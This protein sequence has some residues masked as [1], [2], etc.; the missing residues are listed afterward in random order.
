MNG[1]DSS[2]SES[3][4]REAPGHRERQTVE[5]E[6]SK[7]LL[8]ETGRLARI[9]GWEIDLE[10]NELSWTDVV[11]QILEVE[12]GYKP[13]VETGIN[14]YAPEAVSIISESVHRAIEEGQPFDV[15]LQLLTARNNRLW[16]R[17]VGKA[18][19]ENGKTVK[20]RGV[21]QD[22]NE[23]KVV[24]IE[25]KKHLE[26][27]LGQ[28]TAEL[29][30][31]RKT[32]VEEQ[33]LA[34]VGSWEWNA[35]KDEITGSKEF[36]R[37]FNVAPEEIR[38]FSQFVE[39]LH[40]DDRERVQRD[41][42]NAMRKTLPYDTDYSVKIGDGI[43][44]N[45]N[46]RG[47]VFVD[48]KGKPVRM[49]GTC[50]DITERKQAEETLRESEAMYRTL[51]ENIPQKIFMKDRKFRWVSINEKFA[52]DL[53][54]R[55]EEVVGKM[56]AD[57]FLPE[58]A[59]KYHADDVRVMETGETEEL[60]ERYIQEGRET[61]VNTIKT[62]IRNTEGQIVG[63]LG[64]FWDIT[65]RKQAEWQLKA[66]NMSLQ[67]SNQEL[68]QFAYVA[69]HDLQ[70]PLRM[71]SS[72]TQLLA[73]RYQDKLDQDA[74]DFIGFAVDGANRMQRLIQDLLAYSRITT[75]GQPSVPLDAHDALGEAVRKGPR[76]T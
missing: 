30:E 6:K 40:S 61:W 60:E 20:V 49:A 23:R 66:L 28:R 17:V 70:E 73:Q 75:R 54:L 3:E 25:L 48:V 12:S 72:F 16:V 39:R 64:V 63:V 69:S 46:A 44:R 34:R 2:P 11:Y 65:E 57:L 62:P 42:A 67:R 26:E 1:T 56:D 21:F 27:L 22:I 4:Q 51:V 55:P 32:L 71:V 52:H 58:I 68:E 36:Y 35:V 13:M 76:I 24:E 38:R 7:R 5:F 53:G 43:W 74:K 9:G 29:D 33:T 14:F 15:E 18:I 59:A 10:T 31:C 41:V 37:L 45:I 8:E 47:R 19:R 50:M